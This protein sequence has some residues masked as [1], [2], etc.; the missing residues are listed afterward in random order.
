MIHHLKFVKTH[1]ITSIC[2]H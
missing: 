2:T 1:T